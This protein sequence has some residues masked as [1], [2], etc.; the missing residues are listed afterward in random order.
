MRVLVSLPAWTALDILRHADVFIVFPWFFLYSVSVSGASPAIMVCISWPSLGLLSRRLPGRIAEWFSPRQEQRQMGPCASQHRRLQFPSITMPWIPSC[1]VPSVLASTSE[2]GVISVIL[3]DW[4]LGLVRRLRSSLSR[5]QPASFR[6][7]GSGFSSVFRTFCLSMRGISCSEL[8]LIGYCL[9]NLLLIFIP[10]RGLFG[11][12]ACFSCWRRFSSCAVISEPGEFRVVHAPHDYVLGHRLG[13]LAG[14]PIAAP[15]GTPFWWCG[16][17]WGSGV[18]RT[19]GSSWPRSSVVPV[20][21]FPLSV[22]GFRRPGVGISR[23]PALGLVV[24]VS[25]AGAALL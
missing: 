8:L 15:P 14:G 10:I 19:P 4:S 20:P 6:R 1:F 17:S 2:A 24:L 13:V 7:A 5:P 18:V 22:Q 12:V 23:L 16:L 25:E 9:P 11:P 21:S 3:W